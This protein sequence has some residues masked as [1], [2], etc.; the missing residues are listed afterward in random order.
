MR[1]AK[2]MHLGRAPCTDEYD[3]QLQSQGYKQHQAE[4]RAKDREQGCLIHTAAPRLQSGSKDRSSTPAATYA[5]ALLPYAVNVSAISLEETTAGARVSHTQRYM[6][7]ST[8]S[9]NTG[10]YVSVTV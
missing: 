9:L 10:A 3:A 4:R 7:P 1:L 6:R 2:A 5:P 8:T